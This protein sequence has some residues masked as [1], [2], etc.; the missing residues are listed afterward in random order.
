LNFK[1]LKKNFCYQKNI[2]KTIKDDKLDVVI[3]MFSPYII[4]T[5]FRPLFDLKRNYKLVAWTHGYFKGEDFSSYKNKILRM[6]L[7]KCD[8]ILLYTE[9]EAEKYIDNGFSEDRVFFTNNTL[10]TDK[11]DK[12][13][14]TISQTQINRIK[15]KYGLKAKKTLIFVG[16]LINSKR[17]EV[18][19]KA[20]EELNENYFLFV[21]GD[22][23]DRDIVK[24]YDNLY[25]NICWLG[26]ITDE[27]KLAPY[28]L[29]S[30]LFVM[31][32]KTGLSINHAF[33][34]GLPYV[35]T[36]ENIHAPEVYL[37]NEGKNGEYFQKRDHID[38]ARTIVDM[39][40]N[41]CKLKNYS[42]SAARIIEAKY[43]ID[44]MENKFI[45]M[46]NTICHK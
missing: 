38:L 29:V 46:L 41:R 10:D 45:D 16:R 44:N 5:F 39:T 43:N 13:K 18:L 23:R 11:I 34:Y 21:I 27:K 2:K 3:M 19:L 20:M 15:E 26:K 8:A 7:K 25:K 12:I 33:C 22:G 40:E 30:D 17:I 32:G 37:L 42:Q 9:Q 1:L 35:T 4:S 24:K 6:F 31:P 28:F 36:D 14:T